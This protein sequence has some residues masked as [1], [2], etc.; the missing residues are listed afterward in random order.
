L[1]TLEKLNMT[2]PEMTAE[3]R[4]EPQAMRKRLESE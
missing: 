3:R 1:E 4:K 2:F